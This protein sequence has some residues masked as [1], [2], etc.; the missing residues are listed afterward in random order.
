MCGFQTVKY[1]YGESKYPI[2]II[3]D[4]L[5]ELFGSQFFSKIDLR[6]GY[7]QIRIR[8]EDIHKTAFTTHV[9]H[10]EYVVMPFGLT[11][12]P[13]TFQ[14]LMNLVLA[15]FL[16]EFSFGQLYFS[17]YK[18]AGGGIRVGGGE[19]DKEERKK[20]TDGDLSYIFEI[21]TSRDPK[22]GASPIK[23]TECWIHTPKK[24]GFV[25]T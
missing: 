9:G 13:T 15:N 25:T 24:G 17:P 18:A 5:D 14:S 7:H 10:F 2:F 4:L 21:Q 23:N 12:A 1:Q 19:E 11:D 8:E 6:P 20:R 3:E 22:S 16:M